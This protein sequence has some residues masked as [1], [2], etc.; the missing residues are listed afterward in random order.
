[1]ALLRLD[2]DT[3][4]VGGGPCKSVTS[5]VVGLDLFLLARCVVETARRVSV[6]R[7]VGVPECLLAGDDLLE[8]E[9]Q[10]GSTHANYENKTRLYYGTH[11]IIINL[12]LEITMQ[13]SLITM[14]HM[15]YNLWH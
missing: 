7:L 5:F 14:Q 8:S 15:V 9:E 3:A 2:I 4:D 13:I 6:R 1:M 11:L 12:V 10:A